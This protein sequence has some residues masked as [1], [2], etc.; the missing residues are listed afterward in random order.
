KYIGFNLNGGQLG[1]G[2]EAPNDQA[3]AIQ[4]DVPVI[5][6]PIASMGMWTNDA[7]AISGIKT[8]GKYKYQ[9]SAEINTD[10]TVMKVAIVNGLKDFGSMPT[11]PN[12]VAWLG[13]TYRYTG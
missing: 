10:T 13:P 11:N 4:P 2:P 3:S 9:G 7:N 6:D 8:D 1:L 5:N 12:D